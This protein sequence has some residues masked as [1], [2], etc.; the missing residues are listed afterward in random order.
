MRTPKLV[1]DSLS[2]GKGEWLWSSLC[3]GSGPKVE[4]PI[5]GLDLQDLNYSLL[6]PT[7]GRNA[8]A[9]LLIC[10]D[11]GREG[12]LELKAVSGQT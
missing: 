12:G 7:Q 3:L 6:L 11:T 1:Q 5:Y 4:I 9:F 10:P 8:R 2:E